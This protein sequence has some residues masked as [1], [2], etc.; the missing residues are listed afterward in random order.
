VNTWLD[1]IERQWQCPSAAV[2][3]H[4]LFDVRETILRLCS[5]VRRQR[6]DL[7][8]AWRSEDAPAYGQVRVPDVEMPQRPRLHT[9]VYDVGEESE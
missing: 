5:E 6:D 3:E 7:R 8:A 2:Q 9:L 4:S 1:E